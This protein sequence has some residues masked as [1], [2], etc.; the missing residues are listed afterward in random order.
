MYLIYLV[1]FHNIIHLSDEINKLFEKMKY[2]DLLLIQK[3]S[4]SEVKP[5]LFHL[6]HA[7]IFIEQVLR[8]LIDSSLIFCELKGVC[9]I[10]LKI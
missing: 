1:F 3:T 8:F 2:F 4:I 5:V 9:L 6:H 10:Q 7:Q